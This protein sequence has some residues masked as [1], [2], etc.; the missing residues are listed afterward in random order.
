M[1]VYIDILERERDRYVVVSRDTQVVFLTVLTVVAPTKSVKK[2][3][4]ELLT[5]SSRRR[6]S[7][8]GA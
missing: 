5:S 7:W 2:V 1:R 4:S 3:G 8:D 6:S